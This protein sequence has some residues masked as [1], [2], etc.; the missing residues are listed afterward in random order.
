MFHSKSLSLEIIPYI[1][2]AQ[3]S[4]VIKVLKKIYVL[5]MKSERYN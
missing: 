1:K 4:N 3:N 5:K 2:H